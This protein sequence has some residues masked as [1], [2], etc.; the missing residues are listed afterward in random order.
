MMMTDESREKVE[1]GIARARADVEGVMTELERTIDPVLC[2]AQGLLSA[3]LA[4][5]SEAQ[6]MVK[7]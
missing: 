5:I 1:L 7:P 4:A 6:D 3:A 2:V